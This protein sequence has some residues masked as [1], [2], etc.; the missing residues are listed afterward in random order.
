ME[1]KLLRSYFNQ[2]VR[3]YNLFGF[4]VEYE[5]P[6]FARKTHTLDRQVAVLL[7][8]LE[9]VLSQPV[10]GIDRIAEIKHSSNDIERALGF[11]F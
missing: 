7:H 4:P 2:E 8:Q 11:H 9:N 1:N 6:Y 5:R 10:A 3:I